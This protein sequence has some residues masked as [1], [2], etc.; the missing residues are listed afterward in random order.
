M[1]NSKL[2]RFIYESSINESGKV[3]AQVKIIY[4]DPL[5]I[6]NIPNDSQQPFVE[7][8]DKMLALN[9]DVQKK[10]NR[11]IGRIKETYNIDKITS[12]IANFYNL[13]FANFTKE[14][15]KQKIKLSMVQKD[16]LEDYFNEYVKD[17]SS[18]NEEINKTDKEINTFVYKLY[19]L[20]PQEIQLVESRS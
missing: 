18:L 14:L 16:E 2:F 10:T 5:P 12:N 20:T 13:S 4:I 6:K 1:L 19:N 8:A 15:S 17:I 3:F 7:L 11:F 9:E